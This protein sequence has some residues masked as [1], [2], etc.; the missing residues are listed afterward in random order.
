VVKMVPPPSL[1]CWKPPISIQL[2]LK[3]PDPSRCFQA[4]PQSPSPRHLRK[5]TRSQSP[6]PAALPGLT[7]HTTLS[8]SRQSRMCR[9]AVIATEAAMPRYFPS[10]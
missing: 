7:A 9:H 2:F 6:L 10:R 8:D 4:H 5:H 1:L 3:D